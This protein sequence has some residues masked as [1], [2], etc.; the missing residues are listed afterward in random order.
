M[1]AQRGRMVLLYPDGKREIVS[2]ATPDTGVD[3]SP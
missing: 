3:E 1:V 2:S